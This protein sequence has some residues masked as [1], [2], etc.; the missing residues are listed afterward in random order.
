MLKGEQKR[1]HQGHPFVLWIGSREV[2]GS[3]LIIVPKAGKPTRQHEHGCSH[4]PTNSRSNTLN[5][6]PI[7]DTHL[8]YGLKVVR[9]LAHTRSCPQGRKVHP[10]TRTRCSHSPTD[11][12]SNTRN[13]ATLSALRCTT[14]QACPTAARIARQPNPNPTL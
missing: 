14:N 2:L 6:A 3:H 1:P 4:S 13:Q 10:A 5:R 9:S 11:S 12:R 8:C 7:K